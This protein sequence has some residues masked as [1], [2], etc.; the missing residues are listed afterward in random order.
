MSRAGARL[1]E[2]AVA[3]DDVYGKDVVRDEPLAFALES[4]C[5]RVNARTGHGGS[6]A[7]CNVRTA[8]PAAAHAAAEA[9]D[10]S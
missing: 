5:E 3:P 10:G 8:A 9:V 1:G 7:S 6:G 2:A 4:R